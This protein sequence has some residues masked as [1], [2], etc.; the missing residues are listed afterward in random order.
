MERVVLESGTVGSLDLRFEVVEDVRGGDD[1]GGFLGGG[2]LF[3]SFYSF[4]ILVG[5]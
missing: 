2:G 1:F 5:G 4:F 3:C